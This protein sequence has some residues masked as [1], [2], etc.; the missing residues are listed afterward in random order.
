[1]T[2]IVP[3]REEMNKEILYQAIYAHSFVT[4]PVPGLFKLNF[5]C[6]NTQKPGVFDRSLLLLS[7]E[8]AVTSLFTCLTSSFSNIKIKVG[9]RFLQQTE[10]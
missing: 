6:K 3:K 8:T 9:S 1:M 10:K 4:H 2:K 5:I 7:L